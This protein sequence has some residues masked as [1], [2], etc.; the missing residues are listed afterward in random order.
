MIAGTLTELNLRSNPLGVRGAEYIVRG[1]GDTPLR[2]LNLTSNG[3]HEEGVS[4]RCLAA[5]I[6]RH[7]GTLQE[8]RLDENEL[9]AS[10]VAGANLSPNTAPLKCSSPWP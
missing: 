3:L 2:L 10:A 9:K 5:S 8:L 6:C 4:L 1:L 7:L